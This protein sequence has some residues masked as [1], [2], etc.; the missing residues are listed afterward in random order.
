MHYLLKDFIYLFMSD[1]EQEAETQQREKQAPC[2]EPDAGLDP[3]T[4]GSDPESEVGT[5]P[6]S[7][8]VVPNQGTLNHMATPRWKKGVWET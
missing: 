7:H 1:T 6:L 5:Q 2:G 3:R 8:P 4:P